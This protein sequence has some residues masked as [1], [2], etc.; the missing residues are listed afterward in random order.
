MPVWAMTGKLRSGKTL[1]AVARIKEYLDQGRKVATNL[2]LNLE[3]LIPIHSKKTICYRLPDHPNVESLNSVGLGYDSDEIKG[4]RYNGLMVI[5]ECASIF[6]T[7]SYNAP[8]RAALI[9]WFIH[10]GK[11]RWD[12]IFIIQHINAMDKQF[13]EMFCEHIVYCN[14]FDRLQIPVLSLM[15]KLAFG[16]PVTLPK[17]TRGLVMYGSGMTATKVETW[18]C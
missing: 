13:R 7:R 16:E 17:V 14:R 6:N 15:S 11:R 3:H 8:D 10:V 1:M 12:V 2:D 18:Y 4:D 9:D 5:D